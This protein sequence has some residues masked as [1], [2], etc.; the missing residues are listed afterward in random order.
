MKFLCKLSMQHNVIIISHESITS[1][2]VLFSFIIKDTYCV[3][4]NKISML[5]FLKNHLPCSRW[6]LWRFKLQWEWPKGC[7]KSS[8]YFLGNDT[9]KGFLTYWKPDNNTQGVLDHRKFWKNI[10]VCWVRLWTKNK[11]S[12]MDC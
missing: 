11:Y 3:I 6:E 4:Y 12:F 5:I 10:T 2:A 8:C 9:E 1:C 7:T